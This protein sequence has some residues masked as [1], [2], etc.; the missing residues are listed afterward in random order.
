[1]IIWGRQ[2]SLVSSR[3]IQ[4]SL[5]KCYMKKIHATFQVL[6]SII[7]CYQNNKQKQMWEFYDH[8]GSRAFSGQHPPNPLVELS[9]AKFSMPASNSQFSPNFLPPTTTP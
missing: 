8:L 2:P 1:M 3:L 6:S 4:S 9:L 7:W 5:A